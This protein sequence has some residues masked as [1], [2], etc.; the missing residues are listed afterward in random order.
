M[1]CHLPTLYYLHSF[2]LFEPTVQRRAPKI[3]QNGAENH[4]G[5][6]ASDF[7]SSLEKSHRRQKKQQAL[8]D[9][10]ESLSV[11]M[12][13]ARVRRNAL[14][15]RLFWLSLW[16]RNT[17]TRAHRHTSC[18][19]PPSV[20]PSLVPSPPHKSRCSLNNNSASQYLVVG[21][22]EV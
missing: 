10:H 15:L 1:R 22:G 19:L 18:P 7:L 4:S 2:S 14:L 21:G 16:K 6:R 20:T 8:F 3:A 11:P 17:S 13:G 9:T 5:S 12:S